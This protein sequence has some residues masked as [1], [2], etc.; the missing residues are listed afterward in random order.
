MRA[1]SDSRRV[2]RRERST[3]RA[4]DNFVS[5]VTKKNSIAAYPLS[6]MTRSREREHRRAPGRVAQAA[7]RCD[8]LALA[9]IK[10]SRNG[11]ENEADA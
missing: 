1:T 10:V 7:A 8:R 9:S 4:G 6:S 2:A 5:V 11:V 3:R